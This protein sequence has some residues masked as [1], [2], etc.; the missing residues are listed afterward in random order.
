MI[1]AIIADSGGL[2]RALARTP[3]GK[4]RKLNLHYRPNHPWNHRTNFFA[5]HEAVQH[6]P[7]IFEKAV[8]NPE[9]ALRRPEP[10][11]HAGIVTRSVGCMTKDRPY[12]ASVWPILLHVLKNNRKAAD[13]YHG[14]RRNGKVMQHPL[15]SRILFL[16]VQFDSFVKAFK[17][18]FHS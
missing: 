15:L 7:K 10:E 8:L 6:W 2:L 12:P 3:D 13:H 5:D 16:L 14:N 17:H 1:P 4:N 9:L 18:V 11:G